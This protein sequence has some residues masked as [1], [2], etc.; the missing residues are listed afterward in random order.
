[1]ASLA[2]LIQSF[3]SSGVKPSG[4]GGAAASGLRAMIVPP[5]VNVPG[6]KNTPTEL[7]L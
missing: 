6:S 5:P 7:F 4:S 3:K 1:M 2:S